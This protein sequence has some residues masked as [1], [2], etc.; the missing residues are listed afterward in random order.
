MMPF[1]SRGTYQLLELKLEHAEARLVEAHLQ[2]EDLVAVNEDLR[3]IALGRGVMVE[4]EEKTEPEPT[5]P[6]RRL[7]S[8]MRADFRRDARLRAV[9]LKGKAK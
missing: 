8:E 2:I 6:H 4:K 9:D 5:K 1:V 7:G 3:R